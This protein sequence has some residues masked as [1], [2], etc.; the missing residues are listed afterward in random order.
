MS[1]WYGLEGEST[2]NK[3]RVK[4]FQAFWSSKDSWD[5][6]QIWTSFQ[7][8]GQLLKTLTGFVQLCRD[9]L[10]TNMK[11][12]R[13]EK[14]VLPRIS[15]FWLIWRSGKFVGKSMERNPKIGLKKYFPRIHFFKM[16]PSNF[17]AVFEAVAV[18]SSEKKTLPVWSEHIYEGYECFSLWFC[19][20]KGTL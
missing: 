10:V 8:I 20:L 2:R 12:M 15:F 7:T 3:F 4:Y 19:D 18:N 14:Y 11:L 13:R 9:M 5:H 6:H 1:A 16:T 17:N